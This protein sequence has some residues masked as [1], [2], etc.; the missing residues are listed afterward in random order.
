MKNSNFYFTPNN[1]YF[2]INGC[3]SENNLEI[4]NISRYLPFNRGNIKIS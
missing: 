4:K 2:Y 1:L 3:N